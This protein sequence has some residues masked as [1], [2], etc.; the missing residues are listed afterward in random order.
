MRLVRP[1]LILATALLSACAAA[2]QKTAAPVA[3]PPAATPAAHDNLNATLWM[4]T[5]IEYEAATRSIFGAAKTALDAALADTSWNAL[6]TNESSSGFET[7]P[8]A[9]IVDLDETFIDNSP[10]QARNVAENEGFTLERWRQWVNAEKATA[11]PGA[12]EFAQYAASQ[13]VTFFFV[14][15]RDAPEEVAATAANVKK[16]GFPLRDDLSN[17]MLRGDSRAPER[18]K[19]TRRKLID[20]EY[21]VVMLFGDNLGDFLDGIGT[22]IETRKVLA[23]P[24]A[25]WWGRRW[26]MLPNPSYGSWENA[27]LRSC[28]DQT[29]P[30]ACRRAALRYD[31]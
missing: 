13:G 21:R 14:T 7:K 22:D 24:Y 25:D 29:N 23:A 2:P 20:R 4:Q 6:P 30:A 12:V 15:N 31:Y 27:I 10:Y 16:L 3:P 8:P 11:L 26:F 18:E 9:I 5:A 28:A 1:S 17:L 19:G